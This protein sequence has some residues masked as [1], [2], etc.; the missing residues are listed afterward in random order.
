VLEHLST[1][2]IDCWGPGAD[3]TGNR[4]WG[5]AWGLDMFDI[6]RRSKIT[7]NCTIDYFVPYVGNMRIYEGTG[8]GALMITDHG[9]QLDDLYEKDVEIV[10]YTNPEECMY[11]VRYYLDHPDEAAEI[12]KRGQERT[13]RDHTYNKRMEYVAE[14]LE[15]KLNE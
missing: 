1:L 4:Y 11:L 13:L 14:I 12:A 8:C 6:L 10:T 2:G 15:A 5:E 3:E 7:I 9:F